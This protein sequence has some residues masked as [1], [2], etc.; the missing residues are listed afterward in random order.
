ME[1]KWTPA[2]KTGH[3]VID[4]QHIE[5][6][7]LFD[8]FVDGCSIGKGKDSLLILHKS[9]QDYVHDHFRDE[10]ALMV[11]TKYPGFEQ[12]QREHKKFQRDL[13]ELGKK[14]SMQGVTLME[15]VQ[16]NKLLVNWMVTHV[17]NVDKKLGEYLREEAVGE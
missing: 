2:L 13:S 8:K 9:L 12:Q 6:F 10:E 17:Q 16:M 4:S 5:L 15:L 3:E 14:I 11:S 7:G 1:L